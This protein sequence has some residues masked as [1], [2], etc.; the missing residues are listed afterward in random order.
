LKVK[1]LIDFMV[2]GNTKPFHSTP[3]SQ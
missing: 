1:G 2:E 3:S